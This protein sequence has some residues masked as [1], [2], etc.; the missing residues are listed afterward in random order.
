MKEIIKPN[1]EVYCWVDIVDPLLKIKINTGTAKGYTVVLDTKIIP[2]LI[3]ILKEAENE[4][5]RT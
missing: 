1:G 2:Q 5:S 4:Q 3:E